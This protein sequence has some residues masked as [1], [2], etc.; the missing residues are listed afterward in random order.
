[1]RGAKRCI[2]P[3]RPALPGRVVGADDATGEGGHRRDEED[4][5]LPAFDRCWQHLLGQ[6]ERCR[7][8]AARRSREQCDAP[9]RIRH[10]C[11]RIRIGSPSALSS[12]SMPLA[13]SSSGT[14]SLIER[15]RSSR[16][17]RHQRSQRPDVGVLIAEVAED[18]TLEE[19]EDR[20]RADGWRVGAHADAHQPA[21][22]GQAVERLLE[23]RLQGPP[24]RMRRRGCDRPWLRRS[25]RVGR[26][27]GRRTR[28]RR[29]PRALGPG[30][31]ASRRPR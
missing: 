9:G 5:A 8:D 26:R 12:F 2:R 28:S 1:M 20:R 15:D 7:P 19:V 16:P 3:C 17:E 30:W 6:Q 18:L 21:T 13:T 4:S 31:P 25:W 10:G 14:I 23:G 11:T 27:R 22:H 29:Q 24:R